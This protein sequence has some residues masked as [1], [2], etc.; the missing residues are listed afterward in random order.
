ML[1]IFVGQFI[2]VAII[3]III[4]MSQRYKAATL[5]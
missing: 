4:K 2:I 3:I 1:L 5:L